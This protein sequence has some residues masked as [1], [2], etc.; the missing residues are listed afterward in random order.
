MFKSDLDWTLGVAD[1]AG[2]V[3]E[4]G[5]LQSRPVRVLIVKFEV[6]V[7]ELKC[8]AAT[9]WHPCLQKFLVSRVAL[10][11]DEEC[12]CGFLHRYRYRY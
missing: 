9:A 2:E 12:K 11:E 5:T 3:R 10:D 4:T 1:E 8:V 6:R 7:V